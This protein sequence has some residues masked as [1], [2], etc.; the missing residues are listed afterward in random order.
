MIDVHHH[1]LPEHYV[2]EVGAGP[3]GVQGSSG[4]VPLWSVEAAIE[5]MDEAGIRTAIVSV[6]APG[7]GPLGIG[8]ATR[9]ARWCNDFAAEMGENYPGRFGSFAALPLPDIDASLMET[10][11]ALDE[12]KADGVCL[13]SNYAGVYLGAAAF[14]PLYAELDRRRA[15]IFVH[16]TSPANMQLVAGLSASTLEFPFDTTRTI[17][18]IVFSRVPSRFPGIQW[19]FSHAGG[20]IPYLSGRVELL[21]TNNP[22]LRESIP[23]GFSAELRKFHFDCALSHSNTTLDAL[24]AEVGVESLLFGSDYP[25]GPKQQMLG[26]ARAVRDLSWVKSNKDKLCWGN[27][28]TLFP[29]RIA[30]ST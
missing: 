9:L 8:P 29:R 22:R 12:L 16:P 19:I 24:A 30:A 1:I 13:L 14:D 20:A 11:Y 26:T 7:L 27:A 15:V 2:C 28:A 4:R 23:D 17:A 3:I 18:D 21:T 5:G 25:F 6:S 10:S